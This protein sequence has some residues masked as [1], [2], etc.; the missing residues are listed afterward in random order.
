MTF[1][2]LIDLS[3][4]VPFS[5]Q[6]FKKDKE[7]GLFQCFADPPCLQKKGREEFFFKNCQAVDL[8]D[9]EQ[10][11]LVVFCPLTSHL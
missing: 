11:C 8:I 5:M 4:R 7:S 1:F 9:P 3:F 6:Q 10:V 2:S